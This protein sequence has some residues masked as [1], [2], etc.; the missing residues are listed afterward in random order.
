[1]KNIAILLFTLFFSVSVNASV[2][3]EVRGETWEV[4]WLTGTFDGLNASGLMESQV[5]W[6]DDSITIDFVEAL[7]WIDGGLNGSDKGAFFANRLYHIG[8]AYE[9]TLAGGYIMTNRQEPIIE[10]DYGWFM[11]ETATYAIASRVVAEAS[12]PSALALMMLGLVVIL[13]GRYRKAI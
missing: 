7:G 9:D 12:E 5:W 2:I 4:D 13:L 11:F 8:T 1:M 6:H 3:V 10:E